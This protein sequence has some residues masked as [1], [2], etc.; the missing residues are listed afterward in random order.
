MFAYVR[1]SVHVAMWELLEG[2]CKRGE[3]ESRAYL[4]SGLG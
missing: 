3:S 4:V 2:I 1:S